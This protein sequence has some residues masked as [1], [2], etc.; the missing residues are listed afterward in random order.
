V[1]AQRYEFWMA[2]RRKRFAILQVRDDDHG[3]GLVRLQS[4]DA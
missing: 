4:H 1:A 2:T 3:Q